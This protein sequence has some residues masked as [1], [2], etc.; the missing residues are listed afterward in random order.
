MPNQK[1]PLIALI[2]VPNSGKSTLLNHLTGRQ[3]V[4]A[5]EAHTTRD[6]NYGEDFWEGMFMRFVD[7]G[8]LVPDPK[9][10]IE[11]Q[12]QIKS[13]SAIAQADLLIWVIDRKQDP[14]TIHQDILK[15]VWHTGKPF[16]VAINKVDD[17]NLS[18]S[19]AEY[20]FLGGNGFVNISC[21][22]GFGFNDLM[23]LALKN[24]LVLG[25]EQNFD[26]EYNF[27]TKKQKKK[28]N[29]LKTVEKATDG[30]YYVVRNREG[31]FESV[32]KNLF[33]G[34]KEDLQE[35]PKTE[36]KNLVFDLGGVLL[37]LRYKQMIQFL[38][39]NFDL[40]TGK[41]FNLQDFFK[42]ANINGK[43]FEDLEFWEDLV[44]KLKLVEKIK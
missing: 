19:I 11:K 41:D 17:P 8:G 40:K 12:V 28:D 33:D 7:T 2:G 21:N 35:S 27:S 10:I 31:M 34:E 3:A 36:M 16:I 6:L 43:K 13:W 37:E 39:E 24:L 25:F 22:T 29:K 44:E 5:M 14:E 26:R 15:R 42:D 9:D 1:I 4:T 38:E 23:D 18:V 20:A 32:N 30:D